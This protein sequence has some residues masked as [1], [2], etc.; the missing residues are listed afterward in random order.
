[1]KVKEAH[2]VHLPQRVVDTLKAM[3]IEAAAAPS[4]STAARASS[5]SRG[6]MTKCCTRRAWRRRWCA[7]ESGGVAWGPSGSLTAAIDGDRNS[8]I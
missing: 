3:L 5:A 6:R 8:L 7:E 1:M 2:T 4:L